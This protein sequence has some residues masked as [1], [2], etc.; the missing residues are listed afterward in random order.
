M[1]RN[2]QRQSLIELSNFLALT[3]TPLEWL[4]NVEHVD[5]NELF[6]RLKESGRI[7][8]DVCEKLNTVLK[9]KKPSLKE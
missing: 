2:V 4:T 9:T 6:L 5:L 7:S 3:G 1:D 8:D